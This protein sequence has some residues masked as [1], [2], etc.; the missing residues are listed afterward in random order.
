MTAKRLIATNWKDANQLKIGRWLQTF[1]E[2]VSMEGSAS[3]LLETRNEQ[4]L[5]RE[6]TILIRSL[7]SFQ[8]ALKDP[9][10]PGGV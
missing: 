9:H 6:I 1:L 2:T 7:P 10:E 5:W 3:N 8:R 4:L